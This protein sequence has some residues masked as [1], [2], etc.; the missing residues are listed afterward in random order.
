MR[1][2]TNRNGCT[3]HPNITGLCAV[4]AKYGKMQKRKYRILCKWQMES[5]ISLEIISRVSIL[6]SILKEKPGMVDDDTQWLYIF[7]IASKIESFHRRRDSHQHNCIARCFEGKSIFH[8]DRKTGKK[9]I[10]LSPCVCTRKNG[11]EKRRDGMCVS[12]C[13]EFLFKRKVVSLSLLTDESVD[14]LFH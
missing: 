12:V 7:Y 3:Q 6:Q 13:M 9:R 8:S 14:D 2:L 11:F 1:T 4:K 5:S 10:S